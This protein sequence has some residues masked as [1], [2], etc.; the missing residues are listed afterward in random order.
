[1]YNALDKVPQL[2][3]LYI[4]RIYKELRI[5]EHLIILLLGKV[6]EKPLTSDFF[7]I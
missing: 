3:L 7:N 6:Q 2:L 4:V 5:H 1:M